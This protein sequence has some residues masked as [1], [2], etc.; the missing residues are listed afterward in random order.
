MTIA[1]KNIGLEGTVQ[2]LL[3][4]C[5][6]PFCRRVC[7]DGEWQKVSK[8]DENYEHIKKFLESGNTTK[9]Y[10]P[11]CGKDARREWLE[12]QQQKKARIRKMEPEDAAVLGDLDKK[13]H[14]ETNGY[15]REHFEGILKSWGWEGLGYVVEE[16]GNIIGYIIGV[17]PKKVSNLDKW[18]ASKELVELLR[19]DGAYELLN[20]SVV[21][22]KQGQGY[23]SWLLRDFMRIL[24]MTK[25]NDF[26]RIYTDLYA[27]EKF[28]GNFERLANKFGFVKIGEISMPDDPNLVPPGLKPGQPYADSLVLKLSD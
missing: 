16:N 17:D 1:D 21:P 20:I 11:S 25:D 8:G 26:N 24:C 15:K 22:E 10:C 19:Q 6:E 9:G 4:Q 12:L 18:A 13:I 14:Q 27:Q 5:S 7:I 3:R 28:D 23:G 2:E